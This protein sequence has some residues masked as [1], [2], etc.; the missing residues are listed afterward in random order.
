MYDSSHRAF[1]ALEAAFPVRTI[2]ENWLITIS[3]ESG[4][5]RHNDVKRE[6]ADVFR[7]ITGTKGRFKTGQILDVGATGMGVDNTMLDG[8]GSSKKPGPDQR[9]SQAIDSIRA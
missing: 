8:F 4:E 5:G 3:T 7:Y 1:F 2:H 9:D 6:L